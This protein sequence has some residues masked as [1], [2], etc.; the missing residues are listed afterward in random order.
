MTRKIENEM[1]RAINRGQD[2]SKD[3]TRVHHDPV[4]DGVEVEVYL[5]NHLIAKRYKGGGWRFTLAGWNTRTTRSRVN[6]LINTFVTPRAG[7]RTCRGDVLVTLASGSE[8]RMG[9]DDWFSVAN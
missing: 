1:I 8:V 4:I 9:S 6:A 5:H 3:N 2:W 7:V